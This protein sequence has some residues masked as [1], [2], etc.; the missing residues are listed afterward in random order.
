MECMEPLQETGRYAKAICFCAGGAFWL[1]RI[2]G[3]VDKYA[4]EAYVIHFDVDKSEHN[5]NVHAH[6][7]IRTDIKYALKRMSELVKDRGLKKPDLSSWLNT[8]TGW[9][10][11]HPFKYEKGEHITSQEAVEALYEISKGE[12][13]ITTTAIGQHQMWAANITD[14]RTTAHLYFFSLDWALWVWIPSSGC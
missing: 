11:D 14:T 10:K 9:K 6:F 8:I 1:D 5:K 13:I 7:P 2:T 12:A 3:K 4:Q